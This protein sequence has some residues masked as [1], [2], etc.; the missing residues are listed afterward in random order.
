MRCSEI[1]LNS[2]GIEML[3]RCSRIAKENWIGPVQEIASCSCL[4]IANTVLKSSV[5]LTVFTAHWIPESEV[6]RI[7]GSLGEDGLFTHE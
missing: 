5:I 4:N 7:K 1:G 3:L 6:M 2:V